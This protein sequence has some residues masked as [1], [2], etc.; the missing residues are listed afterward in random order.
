MGND[1]W[2]EFWGALLGSLGGVG[3]GLL[4]LKV[5]SSWFIE[6]RLSKALAIMST[7]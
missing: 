2:T 6:H 5:L 3:V 7:N 4:I 1:M